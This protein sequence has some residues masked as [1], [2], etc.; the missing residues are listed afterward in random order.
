MAEGTPPR[1][2]P[3]GVSPVRATTP[4]ASPGA[5]APEATPPS[6]VPE[7]PPDSRFGSPVAAD[8]LAPGGASPTIR[9][10]KFA[11]TSPQSAGSSASPHLTQG[12]P[13]HV[14]RVVDWAEREAQGEL[15]SA[16]KP[17][18]SDRERRSGRGSLTSSVVGGF[19]A[20]TSGALE[21]LRASR[22]APETPV[23]PPKTR[24]SLRDA[25]P[26]EQE[27][28]IALARRM[29]PLAL[30]EP[31]GGLSRE[32]ARA[33]ARDGKNLSADL[34]EVTVDPY[35][36][37]AF[38][39]EVERVTA[40][41]P[42][43]SPSP[44][45]SAVPETPQTSGPAVT[46]AG[47]ARSP[48]PSPSLGPATASSPALDEP[49][50]EEATRGS[51]FVPEDDRAAEEARARA[52]ILAAAAATSASP[53]RSAGGA[54]D[55]NG[56]ET[57][58]LVAETETETKENG[59]TA[60]DDGVSGDHGGSVP[61]A[62]ALRP[63]DVVGN[64]FR[65][66]DARAAVL[67]PKR[68]AAPTAA[69]SAQKKKLHPRNLLPTKGS[70]T[71]G[72]STKG[73]QTMTTVMTPLPINQS[74]LDRIDALGPEMQPAQKTILLLGIALD[75]YAKTQLIR[76]L[77]RF[78]LMGD[79]GGWGWFAAVFLFFLLSGSATAAY[80]LVHYP[81]PSAKE[82]AELVG[83]HAPRVFGFTKLDFKKMVRTAGAVA[84]MCQ[85]GTAFAAWRALRVKDLRQRKA[86]MDLR[87]MQLVDAVFLLLP[88]ATLQAYVGMKCSSPELTCPGRSGFDALLFLAVLG[89]ITSA[90]LCFVSLD[91]HEKPPSL[92]WRNYWRAHKAH[93]SETG[94]KSAFRFL[95]LSARVSLIALFSAVKGG[96]VFFVFFMHAVIVLLG[97]KFWPKVVGGGV[98]N[99]GVW[100]KLVAV[101]ARL[102][103]S[104][105]RKWWPERLFGGRSVY[106]PTLNDTK[107]LV[108]AMIWPPSMF[109]ANA[110]D[111]KG[112][113]WWRS[114]TCPRKNFLSADRRDAIF[115]LPLFVALQTFEACLMFLI[116]GAAI[117]DKQH[118][119]AYFLSAA[120][121]NIAWLMAVIGWISAAALWNPFLPEGPPLAFARG[122]RGSG[123]PGTARVAA[124]DDGERPIHVSEWK[125]WHGPD[126]A[127]E[128]SDDDVPDDFPSARLSERIGERVAF[129]KGANVAASM[130]APG[131]FSPGGR[132]PGGRTPGG[133]AARRASN[134]VAA[135]YAVGPTETRKERSRERE[136]VSEVSL[137]PAPAPA[138][139]ARALLFGG[140]CAETR[141]A[142]AE[143]DAAEKARVAASEAAAAKERLERERA[144]AAK[145]EAARLEI[146]RLDA[147]RLEEAARAMRR[148]K[149]LLE[150]RREKERAANASRPPT[151]RPP[152][153]ETAAAKPAKP[154][155]SGET[156]APETTARRQSGGLF[157]RPGIVVSSSVAERPSP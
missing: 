99:R 49:P 144:R 81:M 26:E 76:E 3:P 107:L 104:E 130:A 94:A 143:A 75:L 116:V 112:R 124:D 109:V 122:A 106:L 57:A 87:G 131:V 68:S 22:N 98:P 56:R 67:L 84:A 113:F 1:D 50:R 125:G 120:L 142:K 46:D 65:A 129:Q 103:V 79:D 135:S 20:A 18:R 126:A 45:S 105:K 44:A 64:A 108:F 95:E 132:T 73:G 72:S 53:A 24:R 32:T 25:L 13:G 10:D 133:R 38:A 2:V 34:V 83:K 140:E 40:R 52:Q 16:E 137:A 41:V 48:T 92:T 78:A 74:I 63:G 149:A 151:H 77:R 82:R 97:L 35:D 8:A 136:E 55:A 51:G 110:T 6:A 138:P 58:L 7:T 14:A 154:A 66:T 145:A 39:E 134:G 152:V 9:G 36:F 157:G 33:S 42:E 148:E 139:A 88:T 43:R 86:E 59:A 71:K 101:E 31:A 155:K 150:E 19:A 102:V 85:L 93:L 119:H 117:G 100:R 4:G 146:A 28:E 15:L 21:R 153:G 118:Y 11:L 61:R 29:S 114:K 5:R 90:T 30:D 47:D 69:P 121:V 141:K 54:V 115:P 96:W 12:A 60:A 70:P 37:D 17:T 62:P 156:A 80:W 123:A 89:A 23:M 91:L 27:E 127:A 128:V 111:T 147:L